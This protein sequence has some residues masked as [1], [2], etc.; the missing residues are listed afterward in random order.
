MN[1][2]GPKHERETIINFNEESDK[3]SIWTASEVV[4]R[5][6]LKLGYVPSQDNE[7]SAVFEMLKRD[8]KLPRPKRVMSEARRQKIKESLKAKRMYPSLPV[9]PTSGTSLDDAKRE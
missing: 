2:K 3:A 8:V 1:G 4:Y 9:L 6:L 7:R 5:R